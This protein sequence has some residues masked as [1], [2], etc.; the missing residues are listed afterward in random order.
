[1]FV[2]GTTSAS[3]NPLLRRLWLLGGAGVVALFAQQSL[4]QDRG[5]R[6]LV[7]YGVAAVLFALGVGRIERTQ[8]HSVS[9]SIR[10][11][12]PEA[13]QAFIAAGILIV[14]L[15]VMVDTANLTGT[16]LILQVAAI[17]LVV[18]GC[19]YADRS[20]RSQLALPK[21]PI[22]LTTATTQVVL[23]LI[24]VA[25]TWLRFRDLAAVPRGFWSDEASVGLLAR[26]IAEEGY[27]PVYDGALPAS[28]AYLIALLSKIFGE[29]MATVRAV[30][31]IFGTATILAGYLVGR[32]FFGKMGGLVLAFLIAFSRWPIT[33]SR[34]GMNN[35]ALPLFALLTLGLLMRGH[36]RQ[37]NL[38]YALAGFAAGFG[39]L[40]YSALSSTLFALGIFAMYLAWSSKQAGRSFAPQVMVAGVAMLAVATPLT[41][42][43]LTNSDQYFDRSRNT[44]LWSEAG[45]QENDS[46]WDAFK[47]SLSR[48]LPMTHYLGD[49]NGRHNIPGEPMLSP[50]VGGL[51]LL[52]LGAVVVR[53]DRW[54]T[55]LVVV[56]LPLAFA[57]GVLSL[58]WEAPNALRAVAVLPLALVLATA[59]VMALAHTLVATKNA[60]FGLLGIMSVALLLTAWGDGRAYFNSHEQRGDVWGAHSTAET[61]S[62]RLT[63]EATDDTHVRA[64]AFI[65]NS[66]QLQYLGKGETFDG[67][68]GSET[69]LPFYVPE[70]QSGLFMAMWDSYDIGAQATA[71]YPNATVQREFEGQES[72]LVIV[73]IP[74]E[75]ISASLGWTTEDLGAG[76]RTHTAA[77]V[78]DETSEYRFRIADPTATLVINGIEIAPCDAGN[79]LPLAA[80]LHRVAVS[81]GI[82]GAT[83]EL[84]WATP[85][86]PD[87]STVPSDRLVQG[88]YLP[89][90]LV[91]TH[92]AGL[93]DT[94]TP[95][96][97]EIDATID[98]R[99]H[100]FVLPRP[101]QTQ[102]TGGL[103][104]PTA[105]E[106]ELFLR[107][108][109]ELTLTIGGAEVLRN[110]PDFNEL[111]T[112]V[113][114]DQGVVPIMVHY[115]DRDG[116]SGI[117]LRWRLVG[118]PEEPVPIP[119]TALVPWLQ[120]RRLTSC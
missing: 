23:L 30:S 8:R 28:D 25:G 80:G 66:Q 1:M 6:G 34:I 40:F 7:L 111:V 113:S 110:G 84:Q 42:Y 112:T 109:D 87:W 99:L 78:I 72:G 116:S 37:S 82:T 56:W 106:Y 41:K 103:N 59:A 29:G 13:R 107:T 50:L 70:G 49:R 83:P 46:V 117:V 2:E 67:I 90:G 98:L 24:V 19:R 51:S 47:Q 21:S 36:R 9:S 57:P 44:A 115:L 5:W 63:A 65:R 11:W 104:V 119:S 17:A 35:V 55:V 53:A 45:L 68:F 62:A 77:L 105:G 73:E 10:D 48:Y 102:W 81:G 118:S 76:A 92:F 39:M 16:A 20:D 75:D 74:A 114:L 91:A 120:T 93:D 27:R 31:A 15:F 33:L 38:D 43:I 52:G 22:D 108:D 89:G 101:Y 14:L 64:V 85:A 88:D 100:E 18:I 26:R 86:S 60:K 96:F 61:I 71:L 32:E 3:R 12:A 97:L 94:T 69:P 95:S 58:P 4:D 54:L 79:P